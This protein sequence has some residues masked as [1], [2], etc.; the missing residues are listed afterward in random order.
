M[1]SRDKSAAPAYC[2][3][4]EVSSSAAIS[5][6]ALSSVLND[7][8]L[9]V[10]E[11]PELKFVAAGSRRHVAMQASVVKEFAAL[12]PKSEGGAD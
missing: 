4:I 10:A 8:L 1:D 11:S 9:L 7:P 3:P 2:F 12:E 6:N 5:K